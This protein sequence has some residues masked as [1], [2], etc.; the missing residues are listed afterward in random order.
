MQQTGDYS[1][2]AQECGPTDGILE[3]YLLAIGSQDLRAFTGLRQATVGMLSR[4]AYGVLRNRADAEEVVCDVYWRVWLHATRFDPARGT[5][6]AWLAALCRHRSIDY[7]RRTRLKQPAI[8][9]SEAD[10]CDSPE[11]TVEQ[12]QANSALLH[13]LFRLPDSQRQ[14]LAWSFYGELSH[15]EIA[16]IAQMPL[17][18]VK[19]RLRRSLQRL[20]TELEAWTCPT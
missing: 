10:C 14:L 5:A 4:V 3:G 13:V 17:G 9:E 19:S 18:T 7:L 16:A 11:R 12:W 15:Q 1:N 20:H 8:V 6:I 2:A